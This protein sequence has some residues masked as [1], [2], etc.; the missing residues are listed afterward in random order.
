M[1][2]TFRQCSVSFQCLSQVPHDISKV[3]DIETGTHWI[4]TKWNQWSKAWAVLPRMR[5]TWNMVTSLNEIIRNVKKIIHNYKFPMLSAQSIPTRSSVGS[6]GEISTHEVVRDLK[7][8]ARC[9]LT[10]CKG[11]EKGIG[12]SWGRV[13]MDNHWNDQQ[14]PQTS[15]I[16][17]YLLYLPSSVS[18]AYWLAF[19]SEKMTCNRM[20]FP[21]SSYKKRLL[22]TSLP[23]HDFLSLLFQIHC[24]GKSY[25]LLWKFTGEDTDIFS[26]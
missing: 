10:M 20:S 26:Q 22:P 2:A 12:G 5:W 16:H 8:S 13:V 6:G 1:N 18:W 11:H 15:V 4:P 21:M 24:I 3:L 25:L 7:T 17:M 23:I 19:I 9:L 14:W